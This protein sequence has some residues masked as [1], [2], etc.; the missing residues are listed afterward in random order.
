[1]PQA[2]ATPTAS[3]VRDRRTFLPPVLLVLA[4]LAVYSNSFLGPF[5]FDDHDSITRNPSITKISTS[6]FPPPDE[7]LS[8]RPL[9]SLSFALNYAVGGFNPVGYH[10]VNVALHILCGLTLFGLVRRTLVAFRPAAAQQASGLAFLVT[11]LWLLHPLN[12]EAVTYVTQRT[13]LMVALFLLLMLYCVARSCTAAMPRAATAWG[14]GAVLA[15]ALGMVSKEIMVAAPLL[16][17]FYDRAFFAGS[18]ANA[19]RERGALHGAIGATWLILVP[20]YVL[21]NPRSQSALLGG[22]NGLSVGQY[23]M[24]QLEVVPLYLKLAFWPHPLVV[25]YGDWRIPQSFGEVWQ[26]ALV[27]I[28]LAAGGLFLFIRNHWSGF[29]AAAFFAILAP[30]SSI[31]VIGTEVAAERRMYLPLVTVILAALGGLAALRRPSSAPPRAARLGAG[32]TLLGLAILLGG[33][34]WLRNGVY[35]TDFGLWQDAVSKR[36]QN[37]RA[38]LQLAALY[39]DR[40]L[41]RRRSGETEAATLDRAKAYEWTHKAIAAQPDNGF[42]HNILAGLLQLDGKGDEALNHYLLV[43]KYRPNE[44][45]ALAQLIGLLFQRNREDEARPYIEQALRVDPNHYV[46][47]RSLGILRAQVGDFTAA[48]KYFQRCA[49]SAPN[50]SQLIEAHLN[51]AMTHWQMGNLSSAAAEL[52]TILEIQP[53][54]PEAL[55]RLAE[56]NQQR[57]P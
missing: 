29:L 31:I 25:D 50:R 15:C 42:A 17:L 55:R 40:G 56:L 41:A 20:L 57:R 10:V 27:L 45:E 19:F 32:L 33:V 7:P 37:T 30:T 47:L 16:A 18:F 36:P 8:G 4:T 28:V 54:H 35:A 53:D 26:P 39:R 13:E 2:I 1:M 6:L 22:F 12:T 14:G 3:R 5:I 21:G 11:L 24:M 49:S 9:V 34:S 48:L 38:M 44:A 46:A 43:A 52:H 51:L 23:L